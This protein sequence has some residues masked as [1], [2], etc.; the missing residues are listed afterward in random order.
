MA[1]IYLHVPFCVKKCTYCDFVSFP[2]QGRADA[3]FQA[4]YKEIAM[5]A[6]ECGG[7]N[8][9]RYFR[10][11]YAVGSTSRVYMHRNGTHKSLL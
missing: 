2:E 4:L 10:R 9:I 11:R 3:Y 1:G 5:A 6:A 8:S 7:K